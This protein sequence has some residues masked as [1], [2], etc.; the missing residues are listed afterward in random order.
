MCL[1]GVEDLGGVQSCHTT[2]VMTDHEDVLGAQSVH[3]HE[4]R[5]HHGTEGMSDDG[6]GHL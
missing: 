2:I 3:G 4:D 1:C 6:T 5:T